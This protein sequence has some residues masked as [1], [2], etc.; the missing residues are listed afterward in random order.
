M[1]KLMESE[2]IEDEILEKIYTFGLKYYGKHPN[3]IYL[4]RGHYYKIL[5]SPSYYHYVQIDIKNSRPKKIFGMQYQIKE[6]LKE[7]EVQ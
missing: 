2:N 4:N 6:D 7:I 5:A 3:W 1:V